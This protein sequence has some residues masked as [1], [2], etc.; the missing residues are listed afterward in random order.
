VDAGKLMAEEVIAAMGGKG[1]LVAIQGN[2]A[3]DPAVQRFAGLKK[4][5][6]E[7]PEVVLLDDQ[8]A[9][10]DRAKAF[11]VT[12]SF[13]SKY[14]DQ[15]NGIWVANDAMAFGAI[16]ALRATNLAG[17][18]PL[19]GLDATPEAVEAIKK[20]EM[21]ATAGSDGYYQGSIGLAMGYCVLTG[22]VP[23]PSEWRKEDREFY[24]RIMVVNAE[25]AEKMSGDP[26]PAV[27]AAN[28]WPCDKIFG[29]NTGPA[30]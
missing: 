3:N 24:L 9:T 7:H 21:V 15:I 1:G 20:K 16:E 28:D 29:R 11:Q 22:Q 30:F 25:N 6:E 13:L 27:Y 19:N 5:L 8:T 12:Q 23:P 18:I 26:D 17:K 2:L 4:A 14:G 10:W